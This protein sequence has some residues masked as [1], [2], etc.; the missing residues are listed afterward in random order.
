[1]S[2][3]VINDIQ[4]ITIYDVNIIHTSGKKNG[5]LY[6]T[7]FNRITMEI[8]YFQNV[9]STKIGS[10]VYLIVSDVPDS[11]INIK[12]SIFNQC[13][14]VIGSGIYLDNKNWYP[15]SV[16]IDQSEFINSKSDEGIIFIPSGYSLDSS[17]Y[18]KNSVFKENSCSITGALTTLHTGRLE[19]LNT[20][21]EMN[22]AQ[23]GASSIYG[24]FKSSDEVLVFNSV[25]FIN[26]SGP[27]TVEISSIVKNTQVTSNNCEFSDN[28]NTLI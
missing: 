1:M 14:G 3:I 25:K 19:I 9:T 27:I 7:K 4:E 16:H 20:T 24:F 23:I 15:I 13:L 21:F 26:N 18:V 12:K 8:V 5:G 2:G 11:S 6:L 17:S 10:C 28:L 22:E